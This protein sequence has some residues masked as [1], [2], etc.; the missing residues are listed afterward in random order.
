MQYF[1]V[2]NDFGKDCSFHIFKFLFVSLSLYYKV[3]I[4][5]YE[6]KF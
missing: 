6:V 3:D 1:D 2:S 4:R 5:F